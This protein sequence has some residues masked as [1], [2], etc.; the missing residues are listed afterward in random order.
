MGALHD[1]D[2]A[3]LIAGEHPDPH[4]ILGCHETS[5]AGSVVRVLR[6]DARR[7]DVCWDGGEASLLSVHPAGLFEGAVPFAPGARYKLR[8]AYDTLVTEVQDPYAFWPTW[9]PIDLHLA[10]EG[11]HRRL[12]ERMGAH[13]MVVDGVSGTAFAVWAPNARRVSVVGEFCSWDGRL[14]PMRRMGQGIWELFVPDVGPGDLYKFEVKKTDGL[15]ILKADP[16]AF[17]AE[18]RP[19][20]A[21]VVYQ[22]RYAFSD[23][24]YLALRTAKAIRERPV[25]IYEVHLGSW[26]WR[27]TERDDQALD[28]HARRFQSYR[29]L[30]DTLL[31]YVE[32][33]GFTHVE[34]LPVMEHPLDASWG[35][36]VTGFFAATSRYG[37][38]DDLRAF[39]DAAHA[40]GLGV[41]LDWTPAHFPK[42]AFS[43]GRFDGTALYEHANPKQGE[44]PEW[45][46][47]V[48]NWSRLE[49]KNFLIAS[50]LFWLR[51]M[52]ADG[53]RVD[54][55]ASMLYL[56]YGQKDG[57]YVRNIH[58]GR[59][60]LEA[61][62]FIR[63]LND[64][65]HAEVPGA[66]LLAE[67]STSWP[68]VTR[69][70][71]DGGLGFDFKWNMGWMHDTLNYFSMDPLFRAHHHDLLTFSI[72]YAFT[73]NF[74]LPLSHD[75]V[76]HLKKALHA[77]MP[78]DAWQQAATLRA[79]YA[80][81]WAHPGKKLLFMGGEF[82]QWR[83]WDEGSELDWALA[84]EGTHAG[85]SLLVQDLNRLYREHPALHELDGEPEGFRWLIV[86][87]KAESLIAFMRTGRVGSKA[88]IF[89]GNFTPVVRRGVRVGVPV[90]GVYREVLNTDG[91]AY[92]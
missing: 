78:G 3:R 64:V 54:A 28:F 14:F 33:M 67:E 12:Y 92:G 77:K 46:T 38:P 79:L 32:R 13:P 91:A 36:Q 72:M 31:P 23:D 9:G 75:E 70:P 10:S 65:V 29:E 86:D 41:I 87:A 17:R 83:E 2:V 45:G 53:L 59:E 16:F 76:V 88:L 89:I 4:S 73:E 62:D 43:L 22:S 85:L 57:D 84:G 18:L 1:G 48:F 21:S 90:P 50:A 60:N 11:R 20:T 26:R 47:Y 74:V 19:G 39:I 61:A 24:A 68:L 49:V 40:R 80:Y 63:E 56:D 69:P 35:Y 82:G 51:E 66:M 6:P 37:T 42:D 15:V 5:P 71:H 7:V 25:S 44:H 81:M 30:I 8:I 52:H 34:L 55:V 58:G 27:S